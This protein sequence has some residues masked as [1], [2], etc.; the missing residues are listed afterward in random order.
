MSVAYEQRD[1]DSDKRPDSN[2]SVH[3][4]S[5]PDHLQNVTGTQFS[6]PAPARNKSAISILKS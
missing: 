1:E 6:P 2:Q 4:C 3:V 5:R